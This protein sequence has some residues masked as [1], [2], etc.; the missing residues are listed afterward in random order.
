MP[1]LKLW[2]TIPVEKLFKD[3]QNRPIIELFKFFG[4]VTTP[5]CENLNQPKPK[6]DTKLYEISQSRPV[7]VNFS[8]WAV[9]HPTPS[10]APPLGSLTL[11]NLEIL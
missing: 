2:K 6:T 7:I 3:S 8:G 10:R 9:A 11:N 5:L 1:L 4:W